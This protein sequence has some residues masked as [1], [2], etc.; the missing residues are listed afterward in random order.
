MTQTLIRIVLLFTILLPG[1]PSGALRNPVVL[2]QS[3]TGFLVGNRGE[4]L[5]FVTA[6]H[7]LENPSQIN[8][9]FFSRET[10]Q[11]KPFQSNDEWDVAV[12]TCQKP[13]GYRL[14]PSF[15]LAKQN[16]S[17][18]DEVITIGHPIGNDWYI[19]YQDEVIDLEYNFNP[20]LFT[21]TPA[22]VARGNSGGPVLN[23]ANELLGI[24]REEDEFKAVCVSYGL[25]ARMLNTWNVPTNLMVGVAS[26]S[27]SVNNDE[28]INYK[29]YLQE[30]EYHYGNGSWALAEKAYQAADKLRPSADLKAKI[31][32]CQT[33]A[34]RDLEYDRLLN[35]GLNTFD[36]QTRLDIYFRA[37]KQR[38]KSQIQEL[39][40]RTRDLIDA[41]KSSEKSNERPVLN[42]TS[43]N[44]TDPLVGEMVFVKGGTFMMGSKDGGSD[45]K[46]THDV[47]VPDFY[48]GKFEVTQGQWKAIMGNNPSY[49]KTDD[50]YPVETVSWEDV[51]KFIQKLNEKSRYTYRLPT[52][53]EWEYAAG[54]GSQNRTK[55]AGTDKESELYLYG[56]FCDKNCTYDSWKTKDQDDGYKNTAPVG[57][58]KEN[59]LG[60]NDMSGNVWEWCED[61]YHD[62]YKNAP[63]DGSA[64]L[65][66]EGTWRVLRGGSWGNLPQ[67]LRVSNRGRYS[68]DDRV[69]VIGFRLAR[70]P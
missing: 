60:L 10:A 4:T 39:I 8:I 57:S 36:P 12:L 29:T 3:G 52:E 51:Q 55:Y 63:N 13:S 69:N 9:R 26:V 24:V 58:Y 50:N 25:L 48:L 1:A 61:W 21:I 35:E 34:A 53:A 30:A 16:P 14:P 22:G 54:G 5:Y 59:R 68:P 32:T 18:R 49:Y 2:I 41:A 17:V 38:N 43:E 23:E 31:K 65:S 37:Q 40:Q 27:S 28:E 45:E 15:A 56:N 67:N 11:A 7:V 42:A 44:Y 6:L 19:N 33:E 47:T 64:W 20:N 66:P 70:T 46:E 62:S